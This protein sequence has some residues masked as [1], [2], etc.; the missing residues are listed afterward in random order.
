MLEDSL[1]KIDKLLKV[2]F[3]LNENGMVKKNDFIKSPILQIPDD[4]WMLK[5]NPTIIYG[6]LLKFYCYDTGK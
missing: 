6:S 2:N 5:N 4:I 3:L 1:E